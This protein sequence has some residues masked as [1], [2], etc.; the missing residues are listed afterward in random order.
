MQIM[1]VRMWYVYTNSTSCVA[2]S[3]SSILHCCMLVILTRSGTAPGLCVLMDLMVPTT[4]ICPSAFNCSI[5]D[6]MA[7]NVPVRPRPSLESGD[8]THN[9]KPSSCE[10][11][12][13]EQMSAENEP[14]ECNLDRHWVT[15]EQR[16]YLQGEK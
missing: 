4:S 10:N 5:R 1:Q 11:A 14:N 7:M 13:H 9:V 8:N 12:V 15:G 2:D 6:Q 3:V 16:Q